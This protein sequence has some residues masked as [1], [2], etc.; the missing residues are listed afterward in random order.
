MADTSTKSA[1]VKFAN[2]IRGV[3]SAVVGIP[4]AIAATIVVGTAF[5]IV[6]AARIA[7]LQFRKVWGNPTVKVENPGLLAASDFLWG[8]MGKIWTG[9][10]IYAPL[11]MAKQ[12]RSSAEEWQSDL[13]LGTSVDDPGSHESLV[14][15]EEATRKGALQEDIKKR[16]TGTSE[17]AFGKT[18][19]FTR[20]EMNEWLKWIDQAPNSDSS[21]QE[22]DDWINF[23]LDGGNKSQVLE[24]AVNKV[25]SR[26]ADL[27][28]LLQK[29]SEAFEQKN[30]TKLEEAKREIDTELREIFTPSASPKAPFKATG[31]KVARGAGA[32]LGAGARGIDVGA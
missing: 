17:G 28:G 21:D 19:N 16:T 6:N 31:S 10:G 27:A 4:V 1:L 22:L 8:A 2:V 23:R 11:E 30:P 15:L 12:F 18:A 5:M 26:S 25:F 14:T 20:E 32:V 29:F 24:E 7:E 9:F 3:A 13:G